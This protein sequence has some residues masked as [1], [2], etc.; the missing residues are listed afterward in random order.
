MIWHATL[1]LYIFTVSHCQVFLDSVIPYEKTS[2]KLVRKRKAV[3]NRKG[4][5]LKLLFG[6]TTKKSSKNVGPKKIFKF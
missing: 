4:Y 5:T 1:Q 3:I 6:T 2:T